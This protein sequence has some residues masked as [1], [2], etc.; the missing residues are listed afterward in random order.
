MKD[1]FNEDVQ[2]QK[3][4][5]NELKRLKP[6]HVAHFEEMLKES[7][8]AD[9]PLD[10]KI[11]RQCLLKLYDKTSYID[12]EANSDHRMLELFHPITLT[13]RIK[14]Y[15]V[16]IINIGLGLAVGAS[17]FIF[18]SQMGYKGT[19]MLCELVTD[20]C[21]MNLLPY[22]AKLAIAIFMG[23][24][25]STLGFVAGNDLIGS[26]MTAVYFAKGGCKNLCM[27]I[28]A[29]A[30]SGISATAL[31][32]AVKA[33][34]DVPNLFNITSGSGAAYALIGGNWIFSTA[35]DLNGIIGLFPKNDQEVSFNQ[36]LSWLEKNKLSKETLDGFRQHSYF[37][38]LVQSEK[39]PLEN[40]HNKF[41]L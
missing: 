27:T 33:M 26:V 3:N 36:T 32:G 39:P 16:N 41:G 24:S 23:I 7:L 15:A 38:K 11:I 5:V 31:A 17:F 29:A 21:A 14:P 35:F 28:A 25:S 34:T 19:Q 13:E 20:S 40:Q 1:L 22:L 2:F 30:G 8:T 10:E 12:L 4:F 18:F 37:K 9:T 6:E